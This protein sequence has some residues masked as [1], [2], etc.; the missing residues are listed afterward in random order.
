[1]KRVAVLISTYNGERFLKAQIE[2]ILSQKCDTTLHIVVRDDGSSDIT[3]EILEEYSKQGNLTWSQGVN[4][5]PASGFWIL[6]RETAGYDYYA[7]SDQDDLWY[8][9]KIQKAIA[10]LAGISG[11]AMYSSDVELADINLNSM[12]RK[13]FRRHV[14]FSEDAVLCNVQVAQGC[15][16]VFNEAFADII[17]RGGFPQK[18]IMHDNYLSALCVATG[19][20]YIC[21]ESA[22]MQYRLHEKNT[23]GLRTKE[24]VGWINVLQ[25]RMELIFKKCKISET[26]QLRDILNNFD[27]FVPKENRVRCER[28]IASKKSV[29]KRAKLAF[30]NAAL[31]GSKNMT[32]AYRIKFLFGNY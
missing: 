7:L 8:E 28:I 26:E 29:F 10:S 18:M 12:G 23:S 15:T 16:I 11:P 30:S 17:R 19:T 27:I 24:N 4:V 13:R 20:H 3:Q 5:G 21:D 25:N 2:S 9:D 32:L 14:K 22:T 6:I 1:M 31:S